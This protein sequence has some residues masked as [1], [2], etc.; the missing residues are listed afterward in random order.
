MILEF[1]IWNQFIQLSDAVNT[2]NI[3]ACWWTSECKSN[4]NPLRNPHLWYTQTCL[5]TNGI[6]EVTSD[7]RT[8]LSCRWTQLLQDVFSLLFF[9]LCIWIR[10][11][12][13]KKGRKS[14]YTF[15]W[16]LCVLT[17]RDATESHLWFLQSGILVGNRGTQPVSWNPPD[18]SHSPSQTLL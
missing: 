15:L 17:E 16:L 18:E 4:G 11:Q 1:E 3:M 13:W 2:E 12:V 9:L 8:D 14:S 10:A 7:L 6:H 5:N